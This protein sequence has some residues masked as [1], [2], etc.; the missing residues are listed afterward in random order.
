LLDTNIQCK[1]VGY[2]QSTY[3][4]LVPLETNSMT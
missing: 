2:A 4:Q 1:H 3:G